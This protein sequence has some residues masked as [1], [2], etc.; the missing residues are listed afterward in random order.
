[1]IADGLGTIEVTFRIAAAADAIALI[2]SGK[3]FLWR[4]RT[5]AALNT[6]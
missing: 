4:L 1:V 6:F 5:R 2:G 3:N